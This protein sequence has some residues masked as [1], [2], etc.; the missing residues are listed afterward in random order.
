MRTC[1]E[2]AAQWR[3]PP[4]YQCATKVPEGAP[5]QIRA[6]ARKSNK[7]IDGVAGVVV[8][9]HLCKGDG[10]GTILRSPPGGRLNGIQHLEEGLKG[11]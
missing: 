7:V 3:T 9:V 5:P 4:R 11:R 2:E 10:V 8:H 1:W 6:K